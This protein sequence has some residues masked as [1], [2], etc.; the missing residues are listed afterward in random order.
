MRE[1]HQMK[2]F[3]AELDNETQMYCVFDTETTKA[4]SS[5]ASMEQAEADAA[6]RNHVFDVKFTGTR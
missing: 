5:W 3:Y 2:E 4:H 1:G 6:E